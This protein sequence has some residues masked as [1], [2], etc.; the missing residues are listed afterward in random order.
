MKHSAWD[1]LRAYH[2]ATPMGRYSQPLLGQGVLRGVFEL[3]V[4]SGQS[5]KL[6]QA[7]RKML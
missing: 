5:R 3:A 6:G 7:P 4:D 1:Q 2:R